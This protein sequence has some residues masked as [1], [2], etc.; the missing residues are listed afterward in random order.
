M[1]HKVLGNRPDSWQVN[2]DYVNIDSSVILGSGSSVDVKYRPNQP[3][4]CVTVGA[5][6]QIFGTLVIQRPNASI[7]IGKRTQIGNSLLIASDHI[8]IGDDVLMAWNI[9]IID[10]DSHS[11]K[12]ENRK[13]DVKQC[14][15]D[16]QSTPED[17]SRNKDWSNVKMG[18]VVI[19]DKVWIGFGV[20]ILKGVTIGEGAV[21]G[22][23]SVVTHDIP[24]YTV[25]AG[26]PAQIIRNLHE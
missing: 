24:A 2:K 20:S 5:E 26:N 18:P 1:Y 11:L 3:R 25:V 14:A 9:T 17:F 7:L 15:L 22:A 21:V 6:S 8:E 16:Y 13:N 19:K 12:W 10:N 23:C 4:V